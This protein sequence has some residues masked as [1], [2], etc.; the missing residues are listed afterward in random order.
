MRAFRFPPM[1]DPGPEKI[2][3]PA[4]GLRVQGR[5]CTTFPLQLL[6]LASKAACSLAISAARCATAWRLLVLRSHPGAAPWL[7]H[8]GLAN[9]EGGRGYE[10]VP[11]GAVLCQVCRLGEHRREIEVVQVALER[12]AVG[13]LLA[14]GDAGLSYS[15]KHEAL[16]EAVL[17]H[18]RHVLCP[19]QRATRE[20]VLEREDPGALQEALGGGAVDG[21]LVQ[22]TRQ[23]LRIRLLL[24]ARR[25]LSAG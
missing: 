17:V 1:H 19:E 23:I 14:A 8:E 7:P 24:A 13:H 9:G 5:Q 11:P 10:L 6:L 3:R 16:G 4:R 2:Q 20:V 21:R 22:V 18:A 25:T 15:G 12:P